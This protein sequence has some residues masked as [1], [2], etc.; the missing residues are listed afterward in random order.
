MAATTTVAEAS[1]GVRQITMDIYMT[2]PAKRRA[3]KTS[4]G[5]EEKV[6]KRVVPDRGFDGDGEG[7]EWQHAMRENIIKEVGLSADQVERVMQIVV[8]AF[9]SQVVWD[10]TRV[11]M[12]IVKEDYEPRKSAN[13][14]IIHRADQWIDKEFCQPA[15][16]NLDER[17]K[18]AMLE[19]KGFQDGG[20]REYRWKVYN[21]GLPEREGGRWLCP[22][23]GKRGWAPAFPFRRGRRRWRMLTIDLM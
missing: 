13:S 19:V 16:L 9:K 3:T 12:Q 8:E 18:I 15:G 21:K 10:A 5:K 22:P 6:D 14:I 2:T 17:T 11:A 4:E 7:K 1:T 20:W 23:R